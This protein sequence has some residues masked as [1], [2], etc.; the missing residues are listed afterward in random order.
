MPAALLD[1]RRAPRQW[2]WMLF[3]FAVSVGAGCWVYWD[4]IQT[5]GP[6]NGALLAGFIAG[7][8]AARLAMFLIVW[9]RFGWSAARSM[10]MSDA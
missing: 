5:M 10:R 4:D 8:V 6:N 1:F 9:L 2:P 7:L 3:Q